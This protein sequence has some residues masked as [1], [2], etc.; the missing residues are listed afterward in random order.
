MDDGTFPH[1][2]SVLFSAVSP[3]MLQ[4]PSIPSRSSTSPPHDEHDTDK[5]ES[6]QQQQQQRH[7]QQVP[8]VQ[9]HRTWN[10]ERTDT[11]T[12]TTPQTTGSS[13]VHTGS[14]PWTA[15]GT[16]LTRNDST[17]NAS[18]NTRSAPLAAPH[19]TIAVPSV[20]EPNIVR[21]VLSK[22]SSTTTSGTSTPE[23]TARSEPKIPSIQQDQ[24]PP[25]LRR[26]SSSI[27]DETCG[28]GSNVTQ[29]VDGPLACSSSSLAGTTT[30]SASGL[31]PSTSS[32]TILQETSTTAST[33]TLRLPLPTARSSFTS[34]PDD[35][36][37]G[38][39]P[40]PSSSTT[41]PSITARANLVPSPG[42]PPGLEW[43]DSQGGVQLLDPSDPSQQV[44][45]SRSSNL[46]TESSLPSP[47]QQ[48]S[49]TTISSTNNNNN[50]DE[51][52]PKIR[53][54]LT[55]SSSLSPSSPAIQVEPQRIVPPNQESAHH[56]PC[57]DEHRSHVSRDC[58]PMIVTNHHDSLSIGVAD[59]TMS[60]SILSTTTLL[61]A[62]DIATVDT[63]ASPP[64]PATTATTAAAAD[65]LPTNCDS[66]LAPSANTTVISM[67]NNTVQLLPTMTATTPCTT[68][69]L[70]IDA[71]DFDNNNQPKMM[72]KFEEETIMAQE[73]AKGTAQETY[74]SQ[75]V[76]VTKDVIGKR[77]PTTRTLIFSHPRDDAINMMETPE[78]MSQTAHP[79][80][81][82][83]P[84][85]ATLLPVAAV[86][87]TSNPKDNSDTEL[88]ENIN[89]SDDT[90][91]LPIATT[92]GNKNH[93]DAGTTT[94]SRGNTNVTRKK[95]PSS[96]S[97]TGGAGPAAKKSRH[98]NQAGRWTGDEHQA[99]LRGLG[100]YGREWKKVATLIP[101]RTSSQVRSHAQKYFAK[102]QREHQHSA[103][104]DL[105][106]SYTGET[107]STD[108]TSLWEDDGMPTSGLKGRGGMKDDD[109]LYDELDDTERTTMHGCIGDS[110]G[111]VH[112]TGMSGATRSRS[113]C[114]YE[115]LPDAVRVQAARI[116]AHPETVQR[117]VTYTMEQLKQRY[118][119]LQEQLQ[120]SQFKAGRDP[121]PTAAPPPPPSSSSSSSSS[122]S[123]ASMMLHNEELIAL[124]VLQGGLKRDDASSF[125]SKSR[126][127]ASL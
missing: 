121:P 49:K 126:S 97:S 73:P 60:F 122:S 86:A 94:T 118:R 57:G 16:P 34:V 88:V 58:K 107:N 52:Q 81:P 31:A 45:P 24:P 85:A 90:Q 105:G 42:V 26:L 25:T 47:P 12:A 74:S 7:R 104:N 66:I 35:I 82:S 1:P 21:I 98:G 106:F 92:S 27:G 23:V 119:E 18:T 115:E 64:T 48:P 93:V 59:G 6:G 67:D 62:S 5:G 56:L 15:T 112:T 76:V 101:T 117:E 80:Q 17:G 127:A 33:A 99:F 41:V 39:F 38:I 87:S 108:D 54:S 110:S 72:N 78:S 55:S 3:S 14:T 116:M 123:M 51:N 71:D 19:A 96:E 13:T 69:S 79:T 4:S 111:L 95:R 89:H 53:L 50:K 113:N 20:T 83:S 46:V 8:V 11:S 114:W 103:T 32:T 63:V 65:E 44:K 36:K 100:L 10:T 2:S 28:E 9:S 84:T 22:T 70:W 124:H 43:Q 40:E 120:R 91:V 37:L 109:I 61:K 30:T 68:P 29:V 75:M 102:Q 125:S 77:E